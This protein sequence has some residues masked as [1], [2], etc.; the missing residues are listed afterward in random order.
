MPQICMGALTVNWRAANAYG[1]C[2]SHSSVLGIVG[3]DFAGSVTD[4]C[5]SPLAVELGEVLRPG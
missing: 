1:H 5:Y 3:Y 2:I 4:E